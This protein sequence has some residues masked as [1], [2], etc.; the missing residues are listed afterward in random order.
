MTRV[1]AEVTIGPYTFQEIDDHGFRDYEGRTLWMFQI[2]GVRPSNELY[3]TLDSV[4]V[5]AVGEKWT[6]PRGAGGTAVDTAAGWF[7][8]M[9]GADRG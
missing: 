2:E 5:A 3:E 4:L 7:M 8:R 9:I 6:G 1:V